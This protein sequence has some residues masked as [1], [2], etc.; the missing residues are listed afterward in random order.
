MTKIQLGIL[1]GFAL[2]VVI[3]I[4]IFTGVIPG[5]KREEKPVD[6]P[7]VQLNF[8]GTKYDEAAW[9]GVVASFMSKNPGISIAYR[10][11]SED[12]YEKELLD[13]LAAGTGPD[14][15]LIHNDWLLKH[16]NKISPL[17]E[18]VINPAQVSELFP[19]VVTED[20]V[21]GNSVFALPLSINTMALVYNRDSFDRKQVASP[22]ADWDEL[23]AL[24]PKLRDVSSGKIVR[25]AISLGGSAKSVKNAPDILTL[26][27]FQK[28]VNIWAVTNNRTGFGN[29]AE[30]ALRFYAGFSDPKNASYTLDEL[31]RNSVEAFANGETAMIFAYPKDIKDIKG[32]NSTIDLRIEPILQ[33]DEAMPTNVAD[34]WGIAAAN[35]SKDLN[36]SW[37]FIKFATTDSLTARNYV[38]ASENAPALRGSIGDY[39]NHP[40]LKVFAPQILA[41]SSWPKSDRDKMREIF[42]GIIRSALQNRSDL[43]TVLRSAEPS[44]G[45]IINQ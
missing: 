9:A 27:M 18:S 22:P 5:L 39:K 41:A 3:A 45:A 44:V 29:G 30:D 12:L 16:K 8:W 15:F 13:N 1:G 37:S 23:L 43:Q 24:I 10:G 28:G 7:R 11:I 4:L 31:Q 26:I 36:V 25:S 14:I 42:D 17:P 33:F 34:Y 38:L 35:R 32:I 19:K 20:F 40:T 2:V 21:S 6:V